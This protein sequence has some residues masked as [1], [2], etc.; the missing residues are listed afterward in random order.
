VHF[1]SKNEGNNQLLDEF[2]GGKGTVLGEAVRFIGR[3]G[4]MQ[5]SQYYA[6]CA[7]SLALHILFCSLSKYCESK[8][9]FN[10][11]VGFSHAF[12]M[13]FYNNCRS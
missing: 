8:S 12:V 1:S 11:M 7:F 9:V 10:H 5:W 13:A 2:L 3:D 6:K 4:L